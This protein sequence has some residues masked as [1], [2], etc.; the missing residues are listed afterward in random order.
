MPREIDGTSSTTLTGTPGGLVG[1]GNGAVTI[2]AI[3][4]LTS[5]ATDGAIVYCGGG[6]VSG[7]DLEVFGGDYYMSSQEPVLAAA[8]TAD[9]WH[10]VA[11]TKASGTVTPRF[12]KYVY[13]TATW[14]HSNAGGT[15]PN[16]TAVGGGDTLQ[17]GRWGTASMRLAAQIEI[18]AVWNRALSDAEIENLAFTMQAWQTTNPVAGWLL[19]QGTTTTQILDWTGG[20]ANITGGAANVGTDSV[21]VFSYRTSILVSQPAGSGATDAT[22]TP[23]VIA[24]TTATLAP[25]LATGST[26]SAS[27]IATTTSIPAVVVTA[28]TNVTPSAVSTAAS[29]VAPALSAGSTAGPPAVATVTSLAAPSITAVINVTPAAIATTTSLGAPA[30]ST[31]TTV[32]PSAIATTT[33]APAPTVSV[34]EDAAASPAATATATA[35][36]APSVSTGVGVNP[37]VIA[38]AAAI[39]VPSLSASVTLA[40]PV[41]ATL[42]AFPAPAV[43]IGGQD[44]ATTYTVGRPYTRWHIGTPRTRW[45]V[46]SPRTRWHVGRPRE[47]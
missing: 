5:T 2:A 14:T 33:S 15:M 6:D 25:S 20:G 10:L 13:G 39:G 29:F 43:D 7:V 16:G 31:G 8:S 21:P 9:G 38:S 24:T 12:H 18:A 36:P 26:V 34:G 1:V 45:D 4:R 22:A 47:G 44:I 3:L 23:A 41:L 30:I 17:I 46:D 28:V 42:A 37:A 27:V 32:T 19:N 11:G 40:P 35:I